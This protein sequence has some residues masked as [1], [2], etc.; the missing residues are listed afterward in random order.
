MRKTLVGFE[1]LEHYKNMYFW[2][3]IYEISVVNLMMS[4]N[5]HN[6]VVYLIFEIENEVYT[7]I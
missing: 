7:S 4:H 3:A 5:Y 1:S 6:G 2:R